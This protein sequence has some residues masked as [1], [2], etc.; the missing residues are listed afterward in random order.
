[1]KKIPLGVEDFS[2]LKEYCYFVDKTKIL[3][4][5][6]QMPPSSAVLFTRPRRFGKS[7]TLSMIQAFFEKTSE[8][9]SHLFSDTE[10][11][12]SDDLRKNAFLFPVIHLNMKDCIGATEEEILSS[13]S[14]VLK[15]EYQRHQKELEQLRSDKEEKAYIQRILERKAGKEEMRDA[16]SRLVDFINRVSDVKPIVLIDEY[17]VPIEAAYEKGFFDK[18]IDFYRA[19]Y[20]EALKG[21]TNFNLAVLTG[22][23][24]ISKESLFSEMNN[25][26]I[27][28]VASPKFEEAFG[29]T[30]EEVQKLLAYYGK[31]DSLSE[32]QEWYD[33][34]RF[35]STSVYNPWSVLSFLFQDGKIR[36]YWVNTAKNGILDSF[37]EEKG[38][39][40]T[41]QY[42]KDLLDNKCTIQAGDDAFSY[43]DIGKD[44]SAFSSLL[45]ATGYL[46]VSDNEFP[47][48]STLKIPNREVA[49]LFQREVLSRLQNK[50]TNLNDLLQLR[51]DMMNDDEKAVV[52]FLEEKLLPSLSYFEMGKEKNY[53]VLVLTLMVLLYGDC[54]V[55]S[56][57]NSGKGRLDILIRP[58][59]K[60]KPG[61]V[62]EIKMLK[63]PVSKSRL[64]QA[65]RRAVN[66]IEK[67]NYIEILT[68][69]D[70][71]KIHLMG[72]AFAGKKAEATIKTISE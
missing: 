6:S 53:Q 23:L 35:G 55:D 49:S 31:E 5:L 14:L 51:Q 7:L 48:R 44:I 66:Q 19:F 12:K 3:R 50:E 9:K 27:D 52:F 20:G 30:Q 43:R 68:R 65:S 26:L 33:G 56:E 10:I 28:S 4:S 72:L 36:P 24:Q 41:A 38:K 59:D 25:I 13:L 62:I 40:E 17:D 54:I 2:T 39:E 45:L 22:V 34:Y 18:L 29:F 15:L 64:L 69:N 1:M 21:K 67:M 58:K 11:W 61:Y 8:D 47:E 60:S 57:V 37:I 63:E 70:I 42:L 71:K 46:T 32:V 16:L